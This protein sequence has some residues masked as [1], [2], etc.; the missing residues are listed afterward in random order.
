MVVA[1]LDREGCTPLE[2]GEWLAVGVPVED[3]L[4][5]RRFWTPDV[6][7]RWSCLSGLGVGAAR[8]LSQRVGIEMVEGFLAVGADADVIVAWS[9]FPSLVG[10]GPEW[11]AAGVRDPNLAV[12]WAQ[13]GFDPRPARGWIRFGCDVETAAELTKLGC[14]PDEWLSVRD[15]MARD[16]LSLRDAYLKQKEED[17]W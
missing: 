5:E 1:P 13:H 4:D 2:V 14:R 3:V 7:A 16:G 11:L 8:E 6:Y 17:I 15:V 9:G 10:S 12:T